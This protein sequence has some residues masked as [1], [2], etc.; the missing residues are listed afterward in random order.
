[1][2]LHIMVHHHDRSGQL[3]TIWKRPAVSDLAA[4]EPVARQ[5]IAEDRRLGGTKL[6]VDIYDDL[7]CVSAYRGRLKA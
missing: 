2:A 3:S 7:K 5:A 4:A 1:M 6:V